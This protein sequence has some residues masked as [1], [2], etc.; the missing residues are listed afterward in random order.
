ME[1]SW[2]GWLIFVAYISSESTHLGQALGEQL[3]KCTAHP[4]SQN[5]CFSILTWRTEQVVNFFLQMTEKMVCFVN[6]P[7]LNRKTGI[8]TLAQVSNSV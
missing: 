5:P 6:V 8:L 7:F 4:V 3:S 1:N 2:W